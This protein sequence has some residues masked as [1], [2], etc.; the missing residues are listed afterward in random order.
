MIVKLPY[1]IIFLYYLFVVP[2]FV[3]C[4]D[5]Q[6]NI[7]LVAGYNDTPNILPRYGINTGVFMSRSFSERHGLRLELLFSQNS[8]N[9]LV[10]G[11]PGGQSIVREDFVEVP[12]Y[13]D[14]HWEA[15]TEEKLFDLDIVYNLGLAYSRAVGLYAGNIN[16]RKDKEKVQITDKQNGIVLKTG[17]IFTVAKRY[18]LN[19]SIA[20]PARRMDTQVTYAIRLAYTLNGS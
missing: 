18:G 12:I 20:L 14:W 4:Q 6:F 5:Q 2:D 13:F 15:L 17:L 19:F 1:S 8:D 7:G 11:V 9:S 10:E 3:N 16:D